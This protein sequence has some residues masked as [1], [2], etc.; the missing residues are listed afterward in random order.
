MCS[1]VRA[2]IAR[3]ASLSLARFRASC[4]GVKVETL[5]VPLRLDTLAWSADDDRTMVGEG[6]SF[7]GAE[8]G[9]LRRLSGVVVI[10]AVVR[11]C[12]EERVV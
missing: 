2:R 1:L 5:R 8:V 10:L 12:V 9:R 6:E 4:A 3:C 7:E 11:W